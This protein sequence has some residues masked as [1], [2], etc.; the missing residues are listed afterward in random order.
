[1]WDDL[2]QPSLFSVVDTLKGKTA[3]QLPEQGKKVTT[4]TKE[5][6]LTVLKERPDATVS[7][8]PMEVDGGSPDREAGNDA[9]STTEVKI[10][11]I[12]CD[13]KVLIPL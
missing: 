10:I 6:H 11:Q 2:E 8:E 12:A 1:M 3:S 13:V 9:D 5:K 7:E 4:D